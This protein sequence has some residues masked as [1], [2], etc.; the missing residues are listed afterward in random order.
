MSKAAGLLLS[1]LVALSALGTACDRSSKPVNAAAS[2][3]TW[4]PAR[5]GYSN[6]IPGENLLTGDPGWLSGPD[7]TAHE[8]E[9]YADRISVRAGDAI[10]VRVSSS[11]ATTATWT[12]YRIGW[13]GGAGARAVRSGG[14]VAVAPQPS[15]PMDAGTGLVRCGWTPAFTLTVDRDSVSGLYA[16][17]L[18]RQ[19]GFT[20]F[21]PLIV[22]DDRRAD[23]LV[24]ASVQ[25]YQAYNAWGGESLYRDASGSL[26]HH[27][28]SKVSFDRPF[29]DDRGLGQM[30]KWEMPMAHFLEQHGYDAT[31]TTNVDVGTHPV[32]AL[33]RAGMFL[34]VGH[35]E[36]WA[37][38]ERD[39][40]ERA[41]DA[42]VPLA[43]FSA[44]TGYWR[45]RYEDVDSGGVP[46]TI[47]VYKQGDDPRGA[48]QSGLFR[49]SSINKPENALVGVMYENTEF[50]TFPLV[51]A[52]AS[53][54]LFAGTGF[55]TGDSI[56]G[57]VG[58]E[59]D[60]RYANQ[61]EPDALAQLGRS[62]LMDTLGRPGWSDA[63]S[64]RAPS[65]ALVFAGG[66]IFWALGLDPRGGRDPRAERMTANVFHEGLGLAVPPGLDAPQ[67]PAATAPEKGPIDV[68]VST[69]VSGVD[70][71][72]G[73]ARFP[74][75]SGRLAGK[76]VA[77]LPRAA[78]I[79]VA[80]AG[81]VKATILAGDGQ[82]S[83]DSQFDGVPALRARFHT[84]VAVAA[85]AA[86]RIYV[87]DSGANVIRRID[88]D[89]AHT[90]TT[91][92]GALGISGSAD[93]AGGTARF[94]RPSALALDPSGSILYVADTFNHRVRAID[95]ATQMTTTIAGSTR[96]DRDGPGTAA[97]FN[98]PTALAVS[99]DGRIF[100]VETG[101]RKVKVISPDAS[102]TTVTQLVGGDGYRDGPGTQGR[103]AAQ[104]GAAWMG[105]FLAISDGANFRVR[106]LVP[107][108]TVAESHLYTLAFSGHYGS[109]GGAGMD[110]EIGLPTGM[111]ADP[112]G[113]LH[114]ADA[115]TGT[116]R[117]IHS[118]P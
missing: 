52:D 9:G 75:G 80:A 1:A 12:L 100:V 54:W 87:A 37:A 88:N 36:Y 114:V 6:P 60:R 98:Y 109:A 34:S 15:C 53:Q 3:R 117:A 40:I 24:Q 96:G 30:L 51:S 107:G 2:P 111:Q 20:R 83:T 33:D 56:P 39:V 89:A 62:P 72:A 63:V 61:A 43:F 21:I 115:A 23:L 76:F 35:D 28:A 44:N 46:R 4:P 97:M 92:A 85:D 25:T 106:A 116:I 77:A 103:I 18:V 22:T 50:L 19:D 11:T 27:Y 42:G 102:H 86:G 49:G 66:T 67:K 74:A 64:Y 31:Y 110:A 69:V 118:G 10:S 108:A 48:T 105:S 99:P 29:D 101:S 78:Q 79:A 71:V 5:P 104:S 26:P 70:G 113:T 55:Q 93:G 68:V 38:G 57:M 32:D 90:T 17:K 47:V 112:D 65:G 45:I 14:P 81:D 95:I 91:F 73:I 58:F 84:P 13:Y 82:Q 59:Y 94:T 8:I 16:V 7:A 41:R